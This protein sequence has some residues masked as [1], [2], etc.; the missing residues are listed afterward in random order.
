MHRRIVSPAHRSD[1][2]A[3]TESRL[4]QAPPSKL[5]TGEIDMQ[6]GNLNLNLY[7]SADPAI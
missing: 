2:P 5:W 1:Q 4:W 6:T 7:K 3:S